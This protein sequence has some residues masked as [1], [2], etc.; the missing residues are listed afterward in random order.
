MSIKFANGE[1]KKMCVTLR[2]TYN[3]LAKPVCDIAHA[4]SLKTRVQNVR[5]V[6][7]LQNHA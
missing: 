6:K 1:N 3:D 7:K 2:I 5:V 4:F